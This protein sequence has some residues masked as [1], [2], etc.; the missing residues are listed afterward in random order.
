ML[1]LFPSLSLLG[2]QENIYS[3]DYYPLALAAIIRV[4]SVALGGLARASANTARAEA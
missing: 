4:S 3:N 1:F 2:V